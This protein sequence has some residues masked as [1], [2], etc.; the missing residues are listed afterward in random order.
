METPVEF[1]EA[2]AEQMPFEDASFD[3]VCSLFSFRD[4]YDKRAGLNE[5]KRVLKPGVVIVDPAKNE[6]SS[7]LAR[8]HVDACLG[9]LTRYICKIS[10]HHGNG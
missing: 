8:I 2:T 9:E 10:D 4:W 1:V 7:R 6:S 3:G 5:V